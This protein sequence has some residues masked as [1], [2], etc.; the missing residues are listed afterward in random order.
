VRKNKILALPPRER[1]TR[2][3]LHNAR[4]RLTRQEL[5]NA[6]FADPPPVDHPPKRKKTKKP[7]AE[8]PG[9]GFDPQDFI[10]DLV[11]GG[12][13]TKRRKLE[14]AVFVG[15]VA[16]GAAKL[17]SKWYKKWR[18]P[19]RF[20]ISIDRNVEAFFWMNNFLD[21][22]AELL[23]DPEYHD[24]VS[25]KKTTVIDEQTGKVKQLSY[26]ESN[27][28]P[29]CFTLYPKGSVK[30]RYNGN[31]FVIRY[32]G[33]EDS[34][35]KKPYRVLEYFGKTRK[36]LEEL[37]ADIIHYGVNVI[38]DDSD[39]SVFVWESMGD[40]EFRKSLP[41][42]K[43]V[44][45]GE[46]LELIIK[47]LQTF[48]DS[49][50]WYEQC[51]I[52]FRRGVLF[53]GLPGS[54]KTTTAMSIASMLGKN[55]YIL[56]MEGQTESS[57]NKAMSR[58]R[59]GA[60]VLMEDIDISSYTQ[61]RTT[62]SKDPSL[63]LRTLLNILDG[64]ATHTNRIVIATTNCSDKLDDA[65]IRPGRFD[66]KYVFTHADKGQIAELSRRFGFPHEAE[67]LGEQW[68]I[69]QISMAEVQERLIL[70]RQSNN[71]NYR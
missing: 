5:H 24:M 25:V 39:S 52:P 31:I 16:V 2:Q 23:V 26:T 18:E 65:L 70:K 3:E 48:V 64:A 42:R 9:S 67:Q 51:G 57:I 61:S 21:T 58:V 46:T 53:T 20:R 71:A 19:K 40:W 30:F 13:P 69:E 54:G 44:L 62:D 36:P 15:T 8:S 6:L 17:V 43:S 59:E 45:P 27:S 37:Y 63:N 22:K 14:T 49:K 41:K 29:E 47:D 50:E 33:D 55:L 12:D 11:A 7:E 60:V 34:E 38:H 68:S 66:V 32:E 1:L 28:L 35:D 10:L 56:P 4:E